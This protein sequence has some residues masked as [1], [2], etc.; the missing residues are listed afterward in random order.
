MFED[1]VKAELMVKVCDGLEEEKV[2]A[3][4]PIIIAYIISSYM[5]VV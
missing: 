5:H 4:K 3:H 1:Q 2:R